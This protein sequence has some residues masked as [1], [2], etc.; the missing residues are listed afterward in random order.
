MDPG[1]WDP[2]HQ[3]ELYFFG[4]VSANVSHE[5]KNYL[6]VINELGGLLEDISLMAGKNSQA[7]DPERIR[8][9]AGNIASQVSRADHVI[10]AFNYFSHS[11]DKEYSYVDLKKL[12]S[13]MI[14]LTSRL[15]GMKNTEINLDEQSAE[16]LSLYTRPFA[17]E[18]LFLYCL[19]QIM[20]SGSDRK[21][22]SILARGTDQQAEIVFTCNAAELEN[23]SENI[24]IDSLCRQLGADIRL[25]TRENTITV[26][27]PGLAK[28]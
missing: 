3:Q 22:S 17:L 15:A 1:Q 6:A 4:R 24:H 28:Q 27:L 2:H 8:T 20:N 26:S 21:T 25:S 11:V 9:M 10:K 14:T 13:T 18:Q 12:I 19:E 5:I 16:N 23:F 7:L